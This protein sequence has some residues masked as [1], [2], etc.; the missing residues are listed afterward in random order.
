MQPASLKVTPLNS[1]H[2]LL[3]AKMV[4]FG[5]WDMPINYPTGVIEEHLA[6]RTKAGLFDVS[7]MGEFW[8]EGADAL[9]FLNRITSN[10]VSRLTIGAAQYTILT[11]EKGGAVD[12]LLIY[13]FGT[14][15][16]LLVVNAATTE[17]DWSWINFQLDKNEQVTLKNASSEF[18][19]IAIQGPKAEEILQK[20]TPSDLSEIKYYH[21]IESEVAGYQSIISRTGYTGED[22]FEVYS[23]EKAAP[24]LWNAILDAGR[25]S[26]LT[27]CGLAARNTLRLEAAMSLYGHELTDDITPLEA[28]LGMGSQIRQRRLYRQTGIDRTKRKRLENEACRLRN[29]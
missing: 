28:N 8:V 23:S 4:E 6:T 22:G 2:R 14:E 3:G 1:E 24:A 25:G 15:K 19:Q 7:H 12:D 10:D 17:K 20:L 9:K 21:F 5:G 13:C 26:G 18:C 11:N 16:Y 27:P 29:G